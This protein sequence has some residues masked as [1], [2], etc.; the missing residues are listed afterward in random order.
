MYPLMLQDLA[1][2]LKISRLEFV[3]NRKKPPEWGEVG[4]VLLTV[5]FLS[6]GT[7][8]GDLA[9]NLCPTSSFLAAPAWEES[10]ARVSQASRCSEW[11]YRDAICLLYLKSLKGL[12]PFRGHVLCSKSQWM[13]I[14]EDLAKWAPTGSVLM[15]RRRNKSR[16]D[17][18]A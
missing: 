6:T 1:S 9:W 13:L 7:I 3:N 4:S 18:D 5:V 14:I 8:L 16:C 10:R 2:S 11:P 17:N 12:V 15:G